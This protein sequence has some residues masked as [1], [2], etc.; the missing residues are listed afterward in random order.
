MAA[1]GEAPHITTDTELH[2][3]EIFN[4]FWEKLEAYMRPP[5]PVTQTK[6]ELRSLDRVA[7]RQE[8]NTPTGSTSPKKP[9]PQGRHLEEKHLEPHH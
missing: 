1:D 4:S 6:G 5:H 9:M 7:A 3:A 2:M 8:T